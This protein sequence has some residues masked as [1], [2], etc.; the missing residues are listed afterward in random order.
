MNPASYPNVLVPASLFLW[1]AELGTCQPERKLWQSFSTSLLT[2]LVLLGLLR[3][4]L[5]QVRELP[6]EAFVSHQHSEPV[7]ILAW[8]RHTWHSVEG[9]EAVRHGTKLEIGPSL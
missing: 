7:L 6:V 3:L 4:P 8:P 2:L 5:V 9:C 1:R